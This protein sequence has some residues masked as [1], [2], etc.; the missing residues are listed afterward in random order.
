MSIR[1]VEKYDLTDRSAS[2]RRETRLFSKDIIFGIAYLFLICRWRGDAGTHTLDMMVI[3]LGEVF[4][5]DR[6]RLIL[7]KVFAKNLFDLAIVS[8]HRLETATRAA[9]AFN[10]LASFVLPGTHQGPR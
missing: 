8:Q 6:E 9:T 5:Q 10:A 7:K 4:F 2:I 1:A 3:A